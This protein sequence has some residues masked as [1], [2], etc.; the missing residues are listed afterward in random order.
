[1]KLLLATRNPGKLAELK[2]LLDGSG[3]EAV[4]LDAYPLAPE[5]EETGAT[6]A[7]NARLKA[8]S[9]FEHSRT[10]TVAEDAG[11]EVD[12]LGGEPGVFSARYAGPDATDKDRCR[13]LLAKLIAV[14]DERRHARFK[15]VMCLIDPDGAE[16]V[17]EGACEG[18]VSL[19]ARGSAGFGY[20][21]LFIPDGHSQTFGELGLE[22]K[23]TISHR[24]RAMRQVVDLLRGRAAG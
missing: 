19:H 20:D 4:M 14:P 12:A 9:A 23:S 5:V 16:T 6:F 17:F 24:A 10:W 11:L 2:S 22:V 1:M 15:C 18:K 3:W 7:E 13:K 21:P 8:R